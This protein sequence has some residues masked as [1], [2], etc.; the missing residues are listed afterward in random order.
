MRTKRTRVLHAVGPFVLGGVWVAATSSI[1]H[2]DNSVY[3]DIYV[4]TY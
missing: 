3:S 4:D 2:T 1:I